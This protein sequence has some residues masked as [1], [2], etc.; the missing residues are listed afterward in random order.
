MGGKWL[1]R[2]EAN[3]YHSF[4]PRL[5]NNLKDVSSVGIDIGGTKIALG[6]VSSD[7]RVVTRLPTE[8]SG[9]DAA[10]LRIVSAIRQVL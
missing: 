2:E 10:V 5:M 7:G 6:F 1:A 4:E 3:S 9:F 8:P